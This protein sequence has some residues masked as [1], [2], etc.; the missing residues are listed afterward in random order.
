M[1][2]DREAYAAKEQIKRSFFTSPGADELGKQLPQRM[3]RSPGLQ[4]LEGQKTSGPHL[5]RLDLNSAVSAPAEYN[6]GYPGFGE[7]RSMAS[8]SDMQHGASECGSAN[9]R[10][11]HEIR[12]GRMEKVF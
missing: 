1:D 2:I 11:M 4:T 3:P 6:T 7:S 5:M 9:L 8:A 12:M 10:Q